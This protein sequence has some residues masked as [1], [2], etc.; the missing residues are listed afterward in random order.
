MEELLFTVPETAKILKVNQN[1]V[2]DLIRNGY[3]PCMKL[4][5]YKIRKSA[6]E[7]FLENAEGKDFS[8]LTN[9]TALNLMGVG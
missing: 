2:Y 6:I 7:R 4:G 9:P 3:L 5:R 8:D 1:Y